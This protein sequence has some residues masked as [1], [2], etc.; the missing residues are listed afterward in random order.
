[1]HIIYQTRKVKEKK[2]LNIVH[3]FIEKLNGNKIRVTLKDGSAIHG[4]HKPIWP[5]EEENF[6][7]DYI[8]IITKLLDEKLII[9]Y[10]EKVYIDDIVKVEE[11]LYTALR[12]TGKIDFTFDV[13][14]DVK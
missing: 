13:E 10:K 5:P 1:M 9:P 4:Y 8:Y 2:P 7:E 6:K 3:D 14:E 12:W 11:I